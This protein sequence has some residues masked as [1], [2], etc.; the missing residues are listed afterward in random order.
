MKYSEI[1]KKIRELEFVT[2]RLVNEVFA[3][4]YKS[5]FKGSGIEVVNLRRYEY[6]DDVKNIDWITSAKQGDLYIK[7]FEETKELSTM[8]LIDT[9][10]SMHFTSK[11]KYKWEVAL[12][13]AALLIISALKNND[14]FGALIFSDKVE[15]YFPP[16]KGRDHAMAILRATLE[17]FKSNRRAKP[18]DVNKVLEYLNSIVKRHSLAFLLSDSVDD[19]SSRALKIANKKHD[20][21]FL[22]IFDVFERGDVLP[23]KLYFEDLETSDQVLID[24]KNP[25]VRSKFKQMA[26]NREKEIKKICLRNKIDLVEISTTTNI[27]RELNLF[28]KRRQLRH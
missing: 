27:Y 24:L 11:E 21:I 26:E 12:E 25:R 15:K 28:F 6:G 13:T 10:S 2:G 8:I 14:I 9:S 17:S 19:S 7:E 3:G 18:A 20:F 22:Q 5:S 4:N 23:E 1:S 16:R